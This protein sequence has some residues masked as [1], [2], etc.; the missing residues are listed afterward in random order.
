MV[1]LGRGVG[2]GLESHDCNFLSRGSRRHRSRKMGLHAHTRWRK[3]RTETD[4][5]SPRD[6]SRD[7][8]RHP[9]GLLWLCGR[10]RQ[11]RHEPLRRFASR[12]FANFRR[13]WREPDAGSLRVIPLIPA[14]A[15]IKGVADAWVLNKEK[16]E[17]YLLGHIKG[18]GWWYFFLLGVAVKS[19][20]PF[21]ILAAIGTLSFENI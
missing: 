3:S 9:L 8:H 5:A 6:R 2:A 14:P 13:R 18:G 21:L 12:P 7:R 4:R 15:L 1:R 10:A 20:L 11:R 16:P 19:P 17:A